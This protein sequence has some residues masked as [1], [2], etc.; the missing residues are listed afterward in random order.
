MPANNRLGTRPQRPARRGW[1]GRWTD[2]PGPA[3]S[4]G[5]P[6][7]AAPSGQ[8][9]ESACRPTFDAAPGPDR[10]VDRREGQASARRAL[11]CRAAALIA[12]PLA[13]A[14]PAAR[15]ALLI[16]ATAGAVGA[17]C[18]GGGSAAPPVVYTLG[19]TVSGLAPGG[20][21]ML[22]VF[23]DNT[24]NVSA[25]GAFAFVTPLV[26]GT[27]Y[28]VTVQ[29]PPSG[30]TC[31][32]SNASGALTADVSNVQVNCSSAVSLIAV[33]GTGTSEQGI[34]V[35]ALA[36]GFAGATPQAIATINAPFPVLG[37]V[38]DQAGNLYYLASSVVNVTATFY[39]CSAASSYA[40]CTPAA[41]TIGGN[42]SAMTID[43]DGNVYV[44]MVQN[45][46]GQVLKFAAGAGPGAPSVVYQS[47]AGFP[48][49]LGLAV[50]T[51][52][53]MLYVVEAAGPVV[54]G[55][56]PSGLVYQCPAACQTAAATSATQSDITASVGAPGPLAGPVAL[57]ASGTLHLGLVN[58]D[59]DGAAPATMPIA[60]ACGSANGIYTCTEDDVTFPLVAGNANPFV[61]ALAIAV[62]SAGNEYIA[63][64]LDGSGTPLSQLGPQFFEFTPGGNPLSC[65][66]A[67]CTISQLPAALALA[68]VP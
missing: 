18:G 65:G 14:G 41:A 11:I 23:S 46:V 8:S 43:G 62:D 2:R 38:L 20:A 21:L 32:V 27:S 47:R 59:G 10:P 9:Q 48:V 25:N 34:A 57:D 12:R 6:G 22:A 52:G 28:T 68:V 44:A 30:E 63:I 15:L 67:S 26:T 56:G 36:T 24:L 35:Y 5:G 17:G 54:A 61:Q 31:T 19:G 4:E 50:S 64:A 3:T 39:T 1:L 49:L 37:A 51:D 45:N 16:A 40:S 42:V 60:V 66:G 7:A 55:F 33:A 13:G 53:S 29:T 58:P